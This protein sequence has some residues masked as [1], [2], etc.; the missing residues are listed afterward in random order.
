MPTPVS[1]NLITISLPLVILFMVRAP[2]SGMASIAF[3]IR[4][5]NTCESWLP[6]QT[7]SGRDG[8]S[9]FTMDTFFAFL[10]Y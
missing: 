5:T 6:L 2:P 9:S 1:S 4:L 3:N 7:T 8:E 10:S